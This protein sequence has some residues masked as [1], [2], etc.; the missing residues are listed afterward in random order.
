MAYKPLISSA[1]YIEKSRRSVDSRKLS[2]TNCEKVAC[3]R[4][5]YKFPI[6][7]LWRFKWGM[8]G[9]GEKELGSASRRSEGG[10]DRASICPHL[11]LAA[12]RPRHLNG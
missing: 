1:R 12:G 3:D 6:L 11:S 2:E 5:G 8:F 10:R 7:L 4:T 9:G